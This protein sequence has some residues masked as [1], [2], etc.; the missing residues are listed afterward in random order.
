[1]RPLKEEMEWFRTEDV[2]LTLLNRLGLS[3]ERG[4]MIGQDYITK[5]Y[6]IDSMVR[7]FLDQN[8]GKAKAMHWKGLLNR[9]RLHFFNEAIPFHKTAK[10]LDYLKNHGLSWEEYERELRRLR[11]MTMRPFANPRHPGVLYVDID[12]HRGTQQ[13]REE[14]ECFLRQTLQILHVED[15]I[16]I[17]RSW[18]N[19]GFHLALRM[20]RPL[21]PELTSTLQRCL[22]Q[23]I[24]SERIEIKG[25]TQQIRLPMSARYDVIHIENL[26]DFA[27]GAESVYREIASVPEFYDYVGR[28]IEPV[29]IDDT[30]LAGS[31]RPKSRRG[32]NPTLQIPQAKSQR[33]T[34]VSDFIDLSFGSFDVSGH[35]LYRGERYGPQLQLAAEIKTRGGTYD[36]FFLASMLANRGS[37]DL[38]G[39]LAIAHKESEKTWNYAKSRWKGGSSTHGHL[40]FWSNSDLLGQQLKSITAEFARE[41][42]EMVVRLRLSGTMAPSGLASLARPL[43]RRPTQAGVER[44]ARKLTLLL[45]EI[46]GLMIARGN[47]VVS[48]SLSLTRGMLDF[49]GLKGNAEALTNTV[50]LCSL[51]FNLQRRESWEKN[52]GGEFLTPRLFQLIALPGL[53]QTSVEMGIIAAIRF[54]IRKVKRIQTFE[55]L[56]YRRFEAFVRSVCPDFEERAVRAFIAARAA[57]DEYGRYGLRRS[58]GN[59]EHETFEHYALTFYNYLYNNSKDLKRGGEKRDRL[60]C[61]EFLRL[62]ESYLKMQKERAIRMMQ[63]MSRKARIAAVVAA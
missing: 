14:A 45:S 43:T 34:G 20:D 11:D 36:D 4:T 47:R 39:P 17:E 18:V 5:D 30:L 25:P 40:G 50:F 52:R 33:E 38:S 13:E 31:R 46:F 15:P 62:R 1:M 57:N 51:L 6:R 22:R 26:K 7:P 48:F 21:T 32:F 59:L 19:G 61:L 9:M 55:T 12:A 3:Y 27:T 2:M 10:R 24:H 63:K 28:P 23:R 49:Y 54:A 42:A 29:T 53:Q 37:A 56:E 44:E 8:S 58:Y 60:E 16:Y 41:L 35:Y